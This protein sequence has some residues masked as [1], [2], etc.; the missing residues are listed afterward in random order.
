MATKQKE[1]EMIGPLMLNAIYPVN[2]ARKALGVGQRTVDRF[3]REGLPMKKAGNKFFV[4]SNDI[5]EAMEPVK[6]KSKSNT[7]Q[8]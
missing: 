8:A 2:A 7:S 4:L 3:K 6:R 1:T 5:W